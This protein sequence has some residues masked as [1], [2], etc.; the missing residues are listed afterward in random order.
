MNQIY[1]KLENGAYKIVLNKNIYEREAVL[2]TI[3]KFDSDIVAKIEQEG[4][5]HIAIYIDGKKNLHCT[6]TEVEK[7]V[8][9]FTD[10]QLRL[11]IANRTSDIRQ[12]IYDEAFRPLMEVRGR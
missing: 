2:A 11:D 5:D 7:F 12:R 9:E 8:S 3:Y 4:P 1:Q 6:D 10:Q